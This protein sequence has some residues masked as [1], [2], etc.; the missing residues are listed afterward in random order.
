MPSCVEVYKGLVNRRIRA[1]GCHRHPSLGEETVDS[2]PNEDEITNAEAHLCDDE[3]EVDN[4]PS[5]APTDQPADVGV[6]ET[7]Q[8]TNPEHRHIAEVSIVVLVLRQFVFVT[9]VI[10]DDVFAFDDES[11]AV[12]C[13]HG[14]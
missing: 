13:E 9:Q 8:Q 5:P 14:Y 2:V 10:D 12:T 11:T 4:K 7:T 6:V 1:V 3:T